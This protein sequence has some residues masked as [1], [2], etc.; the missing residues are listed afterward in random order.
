MERFWNKTKRNPTNGCLE[1]TG[2]L[3]TKWKYGQIGMKS[4]GFKGPQRAHRVAW[5]LHHGPIPEG[6]VIMHMCDN[7]RCVEIKHLKLGTHADNVHDKIAKGRHGSP[8]KV[9]IGERNGLAKLT[10]DDVRKIRACEGMSLSTIAKK[11][12]V[13]ISCVH[14]IRTYQ[15]WKH[16]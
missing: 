13:G 7:P 2:S 16:I 4:W 10:A 9:N 3:V 5:M 1:W 12:G 6:A 8:G 14:S 11:F 15:T